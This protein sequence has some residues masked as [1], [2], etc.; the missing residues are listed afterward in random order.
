MKRLLLLRHAKAVPGNAKTGDHGRPLA[1]RGRVDA[2]RMGAEMQHRGFVPQTV[3]CSTARRT[4]ETW[5][6]VSPEL[7]SKP[8]IEF[9]GEL[10]LAPAEA[11][12]QL[13]RSR[14]P[15]AETV[16]VIGHNPG[17]EDCAAV[18]LGEPGQEDDAALRER[19]G[20]K[21]PT[22]ALAVLDFEIDNWSELRG[23][24]GLLQD[25]VRP[26]DL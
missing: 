11:I 4:V 8:Q 7:G 26:K 24:T 25:F 22:C 18:L 23:G 20:E 15:R 1:E 21:F 17:M 12:I 10:Y 16:L 13:L 2:Q 14:H 9:L 19:L 5:D 3:L 6:G